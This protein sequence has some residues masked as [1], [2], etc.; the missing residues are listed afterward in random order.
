MPDQ[1][2]Y[3]GLTKDGKWVKGWYV[4]AKRKH[5]IITQETDVHEV[6]DDDFDGIALFTYTKCLSG[7]VEAIP[8]TVGQ[9]TGLTEENS[10]KA[11]YQHDIVLCHCAR[12]KQILFKGVIK[13]HAP[14]FYLACFWQKI[15]GEPEE[16]YPVGDNNRSL[17]QGWW[18]ID[19]ILGN[20]HQNSELL[21]GDE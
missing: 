4:E 20:I 6:K 13:Y 9:F 21:K 7:L 18:P 1:R 11:V 8:E 12:N 16:W 15:E 2:Q 14:E 19:K 5:Y 17:I 10:K 3:R